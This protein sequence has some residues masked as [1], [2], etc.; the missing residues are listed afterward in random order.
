MH[1]TL[2]DETKEPFFYT[3]NSVIIEV[4]NEF[5]NFTG[6]SRDELIGKSLL[7]ISY[8][9]RI[10]SEFSLENIKNGCGFYIFTKKYDE[11][12]V[13]ITCKLL[14]L[15]NEKIYFFKEKINLRIENKFPIINKFLLDNNVGVAIYN[16]PNLAL[17]KANQY[18]LDL[19]GKLYNTKET[20]IGKKASNF[21]YLWESSEWKEIVTNV[22][23]TGQS[24]LRKEIKEYNQNWKELYIDGNII[25]VTEKG[26]VK[27]IILIKE[28]VTEKVLLRKSSQEQAKII[29]KQKEKLEII[30]ENM[31]D[32]LFMIDKDYKYILLNNSAREFIFNFH[33][34]KSVGDSLSYIKYYDSLGNLVP[35]KDLPI[36]KVL[37][38]EKIKEFRFTFGMKDEIR[39]FDISGSPIYDSKGGFDSGIIIVRNVTDK[40]KEE[41]NRLL[42]TQLNFFNNMIANLKVGF[43][44]Y[45]YPEYKIIEINNKTY[46]DLEQINPSVGDVSSIIGKNLFNIFNYSKDEE[47]EFRKNIENIVDKKV[48]SNFDYHK[49][50]LSGEERFLKL[51]HQPLVGINGKALE[52]I[53]ISTD[54]TDEV[55]A[56]NQM[57]KIFEIHEELFANVSHELKT[58]LNV[59]FSTDQLMELYLKKGLVEANKEKV[60]RDVNIIKQNCY[61]LTKLINNIVDLSKIESGFFKLNLSNEN[62]VEVTENIVQSVSEYIKRKEINIIFDTNI[63][64]KIIACDPEKIERIILNLISNAIKFSNLGGSIFIKVLD[65][66]SI[67]EISVEDTG[68]G[69]EKKY[70]D[71]IFGR[72]QQV[73]KSLSRN[74]EGSG[75]GLSL[76]KSIVEMHGGKISVDSEIGK[77]SIFK[78]ELPARIIKSSKV[79]EKNKQ[80]NNK[81]QMI[82]VE[83][84][85]IYSI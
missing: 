32:G 56:K 33:P 28:D 27:Y 4:N 64:E 59:I 67:V 15:E 31:S 2:N 48:N 74:V 9:L 42:K 35:V 49:F 71:N 68:I 60:F 43:V 30:L 38:G 40:V 37:K 1:Y 24:F 21:I 41:E 20:A 53:D 34:L 61:R 83:F 79:I 12:W 8:M 17:L 19:L 18:Y 25:P 72:F 45:S 10:D 55:K 14:E 76:V 36:T 50:Y 22:I 39:N 16:V 26:K 51:I 75:I 69:I 46:D 82:N 63:E 57:K 62:I 81:I 3:K 7:E 85:D 52:M 54:I 23:N 70:L 66:G 77:G 44:R 6:Y 58:P 84:S 5:I 47:A 65:K 29:N 13:S 78:V 73:D 80:I 11:R